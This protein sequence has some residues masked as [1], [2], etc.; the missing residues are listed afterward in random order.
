VWNTRVNNPGGSTGTG[1][2]LAVSSVIF[3][4]NFVG[5]GVA[6][7]FQLTSGVDNATFG[8]G[9]WSASRILNTYPAHVTKDNN[10]P[11]NDSSNIFTRSRINVSSISAGGLVTLSAAPLNLENIRIWYFYNL[12]NADTLSAY[13]QDDFVAS[14]EEES[15]SFNA[16][17]LAFGSSSGDL[18]DDSTNLYFD[19]STKLLKVGGLTASEILI[20]DASK[21][22]VSGA[23][24]TYPSLTE[25]SYVKGVTSAIQTQLNS[26]ISSVEGT[27]VLSTGEVGG[28][29]YLR[30]NGDGT[31]SWQTV[32]G[33]SGLT[34][35]QVMA[36]LSIGF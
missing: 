5:D 11:I 30:E 21:N 9:S 20:T 10:K 18:I 25:I 29:K 33:G 3:R 19:Y 24:A 23:V 34:H 8:S 35:P 26:K 7:T 1:G 31:C 4:E 12:Q 15:A 16:G 27:A 6:T 22:I 13:Q 32:T 14:M 2:T 36:R 17:G 28:T